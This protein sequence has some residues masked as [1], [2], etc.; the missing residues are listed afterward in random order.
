MFKSLK[1]II[2]VASL[3]FFISACSGEELLPPT[4]MEF[5]GSTLTW[6]NGSDVEEYLIV[7]T[8]SGFNRRTKGNVLN[9]DFDQ[10]NYYFKMYTI[11]ANDEQSSVLE[12]TFYSLDDVDTI[13]FQN[14]HQVVWEKVDNATSYEVNVNGVKSNTRNNYFEAFEI[15]Q[16]TI[17]I[18]P[19]STSDVYFSKEPAQHTFTKLSDEFNLI[20]SNGMLMWDSIYKASTYE[21]S[22]NGNLHETTSNTF[23]LFN[24]NNNDFVVNIKSKS[25]Q[26]DVMNSELSENMNFKYKEIVTNFQITN[27]VLYWD[28]VEDATGYKIKVNGVVIEDDLNSNE[29]DG[30]TSN[31]ETRIQVQ[32]TFE[33]V[34]NNTYFTDWTDEDVFSILEAP[35]L[36]WS[37]NLSVNDVQTN[38]I[39]W[40]SINN[41]VGYNIK[42]RSPNGEEVIFNYGR[43]QRT[44]TNQ[45]DSPGLYLV[46]VSA[47]SAEGSSISSSKFSSPINIT[48]LESPKLAE[49]NAIISN[50]N[51]NADGFT[52]T[53]ENVEGAKSYELYK[54][55][56]LFKTTNSQQMIVNDFI[57][58]QIVEGQEINFVLKSKGDYKTL[59][60][61][62]YVNLDSLTS[63]ST[64]FKIEVQPSI[65]NYEMKGYE[66][67]WDDMES[68]DGY[69]LNINGTNSIVLSNSENLDFLTTGVNDLQL[70]LRGNGTTVLASNP[71]SMFRI[72]RLASPTN[73]RIGTIVAEGQLNFDG[74]TNA[75]SYN[76]VLDTQENPIPVDNLTNINQYITE[77][78]TA[79]HMYSIANYYDSNSGLYYMTSP[80]SRTYQF[81]KLA[82]PTFPDDAFTNDMFNWNP[83]A[84][85]NLE[86]YT[87]TYIVYNQNKLSYNNGSIQ[88]SMNIGTFSGGETY[89][90]YVRAIGD[91][92][93]YVNSDYSLAKSIT[94]LT[95]PT[96]SVVDNQYY[97]ENVVGASSYNLYI[98]GE[99]AQSFVQGT[100]QSFTYTPFF[101]ELK[102]YNV[103]LVAVGDGGITRIDSDEFVFTQFTKQLINPSF[104]FGYSLE[105][106]DTNGTLQMNIESVS[107]NALGYVY[108]IGGSEFYS[109]ALTYEYQGLSSGSYTLGV[110]A[111]GGKIDEFNNYYIN[112]QITGNNSTSK[113]DI[114]PPVGSDNIN[115]SFDGR[116]SWQA[117]ENAFGYELIVTF[118][119]GE[120]VYEFQ[121]TRNYF[122][123]DFENFSIVKIEIRTLGNGR[124]VITSEVSLKE[125]SLT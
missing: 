100:K 105:Y 119:H 77:Q 11:N 22:I 95:T 91:G 114:L 124:N 44:F 29:Y 81:I 28:E 106:Y 23:S 9:I 78:G 73:I 61:Q 97:W 59:G 43:E 19:L 50:P 4:M 42:L 1:A 103:T 35:T 47:V 70:N 118:D 90:F 79:L 108:I 71:T 37:Q 63:M 40:D 67:S 117:V 33:L 55:N 15:G 125:F 62:I 76:V 66:L 82:A 18:K 99:L 113:L 94:K 93:N 101:D 121:T 80:S 10:K 115:L 102:V 72:I 39:V 120:K 112:S 25:T 123:V 34:E 98:D 85:V 56:S 13:D 24:S 60:G 31:Q 57:D 41:A 30:L 21:V 111:K 51:S 17:S 83:S 104:S 36:T 58:Q 46:S 109:E 27:G 96:L 92:T 86:V 26:Q 38:A 14:E 32:P 49:F 64:S 69:S 84:N 110:Y 88:N 53:Y 68:G 54:D 107:Q 65:I 75:L 89:T 45:F 74:V 12:K 2:L 122:D 8:F 52:L 87:P 6:N 116:I 5:D 20:Y 7:E 48:R 3:I 16:N